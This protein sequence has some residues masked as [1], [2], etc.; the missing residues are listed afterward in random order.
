MPPIDEIKETIIRAIPLS[1]SQVINNLLKVHHDEQIYQMA[2]DEPVNIS[3]LAR[4]TEANL[5]CLG[6]SC[7]AWQKACHIMGTV[8]ASACCITSIDI[9]AAISG[10]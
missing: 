8:L 6:I 7:H 9:Q 1:L 5:P 3:S 10:G 4:G 2:R